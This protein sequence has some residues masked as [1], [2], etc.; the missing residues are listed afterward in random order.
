MDTEKKTALYET[1]KKLNGNIVNFHGVMLPVFYSSIQEEHNSVRNNMGIFDVSHMGNVIVEF[2]DK[3]TAIRKLNYLLPNDYSKTRPGKIIYSTL[4]QDD[5]TVID[6]IL[7]MNL[8]DKVFHI[9]VNSAN[10]E[11]DFNW[12]K[13]QLTPDGIKVE[14]LSDKFGIIALQG[15]NACNF[16]EKEFHFPVNTLKSFEVLK[17]QYDGNEILISRTGYTGED[18]CEIIIDNKNVVKLFTEILE[19][20]KKYNLIPCGLGARDTLRLESALPLYGQELDDKHSPIQSMMSWSV[21]LN[22]AGDFIGKKAIIEGQ[23]N[24]F[25]DVM[26]GFEVE[27]RS[28][29]RTGMEIVNKNDMTIGIVTSGTFSPTLKKNIGIAYIKSEYSADEDLKIKIRNKIEKIKIVKLP[30]YKRMKP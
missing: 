19:K 5:G 20:G 16:L 6:D 29:P 13:K 9:V 10:I 4:L 23:N 21:K 11:K 15:P 25:S 12:I 22:K 3:E 27:S 28:I 14:N 26:I 1:H 24:R 8:D 30:F 7:V 18:G 2:P 17:T